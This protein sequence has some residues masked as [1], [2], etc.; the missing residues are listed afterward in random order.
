[1]KDKDFIKKLRS[2]VD[3]VVPDNK[4]IIKS[5]L[6]I[7]QVK[8]GRNISYK[9]PLAALSLVFALVLG[10][11]IFKPNK[12]VNLIGTTYL[13]IDVNPSIELTVNEK[14]I[15]TS[16]L[17]K[18][19]KAKALLV[20][21]QFVGKSIDEATTILVDLFNEA[22]YLS[23]T[24][25]QN[26]V[27]VTAINDD[28]KTHDYIEE[29]VSNE[30]NNFFNQNYIFG[31][32][33]NGQNVSNSSLEEQAAFYN[34]SLG[35]MQLINTIL[36]L[37]NRNDKNIPT[38]EQLKD[39]SVASLNEMLEDL[40]EQKEDEIDDLEDDIEDLV[41]LMEDYE[42]STN[43]HKNELEIK[44]NNAFIQIKNKYGE[45][46]FKDVV[47]NFDN[48]SATIRQLEDIEDFLDDLEEDELL[49]LINNSKNYNINQV[50]M[51]KEKEKDKLNGFNYEQ[52]YKEYDE[53]YEEWLEENKIK[54]E[55]NWFSLK[56]EWEKY[57]ED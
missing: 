30:F 2:E 7:Y 31:V 23:I 54:Y 21:Q 49:K 39:K 42:E 12:N 9:K 32:V 47:I 3:L 1:M 34:I 50:N 43:D 26:A 27:M 52:A 15:V 48:I 8:K 19:N 6:G 16:C 36:S 28:K 40:I 45:E 5:R 24:N 56:E 35:K 17:P 11:I 20:N 38:I 53:L 57:F 22:G 13:S 25:K 4:E 37:Y 14:L 33:V 51:L 29:R 44:I 18:N 10:F 41:D 46:I 55:N